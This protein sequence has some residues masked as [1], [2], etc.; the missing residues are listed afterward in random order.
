MKTPAHKQ[1]D[2]SKKPSQIINPIQNKLSFEEW[3]DN[4]RKSHG[5]YNWWKTEDLMVCWKE[6]QENK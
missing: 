6:A 2:P 1:T 3:L 4:Y 5:N